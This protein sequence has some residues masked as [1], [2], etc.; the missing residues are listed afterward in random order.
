M[1]PSLPHLHPP[2]FFTYN[3]D[4]IAKGDGRTCC[5]LHSTPKGSSNASLLS[6]MN[7]KKPRLSCMNTIDACSVKSVGK[8]CFRTQHM[9]IV[10]AFSSDT[11]SLV[12]KTRYLWWLFR[13][14]EILQDIS[15]HRGSKKEGMI[16]CAELWRYA[17]FSSS[18]CTLG[19]PVFISKCNVVPLN[20]YSLA[21]CWQLLMACEGYPVFGCN[22]TERRNLRYAP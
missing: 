18:E 1:P 17:S 8:V 5:N 16:S 22:F 13:I 3:I 11:D 10:D 20:N 6:P 2:F 9:D 4:Q 12:G 7:D 15:S 21:S 14:L 19:A